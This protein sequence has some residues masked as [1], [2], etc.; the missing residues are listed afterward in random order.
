M[1][2]HQKNSRRYHQNFL[3]YNNKKITA[4]I[5]DLF[6]SKEVCVVAF[7]KIIQQQTI[8]KLANSIVCLWAN[9]FCLQQ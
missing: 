9:N 7:F 3:L 5:A 1:K 8:G 4:Y 2:Q 6:K